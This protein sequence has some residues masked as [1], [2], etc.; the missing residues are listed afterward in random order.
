MSLQN[1]DITEKTVPEFIE[2]C[3]CLENLEETEGAMTKPKV[4][5]RTKVSTNTRQMT[6]GSQ[7]TLK[8]LRDTIAFFM[9]M[10]TIRLMNV[11]T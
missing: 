7:K 3:K 8:T 9:V 1:F 5:L 11:E 10:V 6:K 2:F 4:L